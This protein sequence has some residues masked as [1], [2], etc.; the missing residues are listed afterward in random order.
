MIY[1]LYYTLHLI[2]LLRGVYETG[3]DLLNHPK[4]KYLVYQL[5]KNQYPQLDDD[6]AWELLETN[7][8]DSSDSENTIPIK[9]TKTILK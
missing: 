7:S 2:S 8:F 6:E 5:N 1:E 9:I 3:I 4:I